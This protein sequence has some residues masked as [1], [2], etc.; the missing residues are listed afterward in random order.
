MPDLFDLRLDDCPALN[1]KQAAAF[2]AGGTGAVQALLAAKAARSDAKLA[3]SEV[4]MFQVGGGGG[5]CPAGGSAGRPVTRAPPPSPRSSTQPTQRRTRAS[6]KSSPSSRQWSRRSGVRGAG[7]GAREER[8]P[9]FLPHPRPPPAPELADLRLVM[10]NAGR[11]FPRA[12]PSDIPAA[13]A[14]VQRRHDELCADNA[15]KRAAAV[16]PG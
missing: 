5:R 8:P 11:L 14:E 3:L 2:T 6:C 15:R 12:L 10:R 9:P 7:A 4:L 16:R 13:V 1:A